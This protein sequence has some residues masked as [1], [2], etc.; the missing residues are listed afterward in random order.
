M[1]FC[2]T[3]DSE[4]VLCWSA[5]L[6]PTRMRT[7]GACSA[8]VPQQGDTE[9]ELAAYCPECASREFDE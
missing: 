8:D 6:R 9:P 7:A 1:L 2:A 5:A 3:T 4:L